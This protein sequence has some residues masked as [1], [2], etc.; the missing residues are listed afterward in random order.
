MVVLLEESVVLYRPLL[1]L[2]V[3]TAA[4]DAHYTADPAGG[5][6]ARERERETCT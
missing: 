6:R 4:I 5:E 1:E 2:H 3:H